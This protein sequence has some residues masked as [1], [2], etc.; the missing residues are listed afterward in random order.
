V[1]L[2]Q[3]TTPKVVIGTESWLNP[4]TTTMRRF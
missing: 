3:S 1:N 4:N 2:I